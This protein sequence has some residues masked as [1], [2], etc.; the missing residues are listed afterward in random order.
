MGGDVRVQ[1]STN[2]YVTR[3]TVG[4]SVEIGPDDKVDIDTTSTTEENENG[5]TIR[6]VIETKTIT[7]PNGDVRVQTATQRFVTKKATA[8]NMVSVGMINED[9]E[10]TVDVSLD[11]EETEEGI[12]RTVTEKKTIKSPDGSKRVETSKQ[13]YVTK[14]KTI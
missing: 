6:T 11:T 13:R 10:V 3:K 1:T 8:G 7:S 4:E 14:T 12:V 5:D 9:D 2:R